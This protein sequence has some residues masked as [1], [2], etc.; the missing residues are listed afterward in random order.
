MCLNLYPNQYPKK[1]PKIVE[2]VNNTIQNIKLNIELSKGYDTSPVL[3]IITPEIN[4]RGSPGRKNPIIIPVS[5]NK[6][7]KT[8]YNP[9]FFIIQ[10]G[11]NK[12]WKDSI[13]AS[14]IF[15]F[16]LHICKYDEYLN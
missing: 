16:S 8:K 13:R 3:A 10:F 7:N 12:Y 14:I 15:S 9:P 11:S 2:T 5:I 4:R 1:L 6:I